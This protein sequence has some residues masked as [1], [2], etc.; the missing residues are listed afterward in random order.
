MCCLLLALQSHSEGG[1]CTHHLCQSLH[2]YLWCT[3][4]LD[5][6]ASDFHW[7]NLRVSNRENSDL[8]GYST[9]PCQSTVL[10]MIIQLVS[11]LSGLMDGLPACWNHS[12]YPS[13]TLSYAGINQ[14]LFMVQH[15]VVLIISLPHIASTICLLPFSYKKT[16]SSEKQVFLPRRS[17]YHEH[18][19]KQHLGLSLA[20]LGRTCISNWW[21][22]HGLR[23]FHVVLKGTP[24]F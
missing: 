19:S 1:T 22:A 14:S 21:K 24:N 17:K 8:A 4:C 9:Q 20:E 11:H 2:Q 3:H 23:I 7:I 13:L 15:R 12:W 5:N 6:L 10:E 18:I 16:P